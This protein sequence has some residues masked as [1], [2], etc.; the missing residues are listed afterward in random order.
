M[1]KGTVWITRSLP[2]ARQ[3]AD[4][5]QAAGF[6]TYINPLIRIGVP[7]VMPQPLDKRD[8]LLITSTNAL[9]F[10]EI[11]TDRRDWPV[12]TVGDASAHYARKMGFV[13]VL[14]ARG[15]AKDLLALSQKIYSPNT[16]R[17]FVYA[18][19]RHVSFDL[20]ETLRA[21]G[22]KARRDI[23]YH[24]DVRQYANIDSAPPL[25]HLAVYS[26]MAARAARRF[27]GQVNGAKT[28]SI[29]ANADK[30]LGERYKNR[31]LIAGRPNEQAMIKAVSA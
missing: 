5:W 24:N 1:S 15:T 27:A 4:A 19:A 10:L 2:G 14:S 17:T 9:R 6:E 18:S 20:S 26:P 3:S 8:V 16:P 28:I 21:R 12:M 22:F 7:K 25:T 13:D 30:A 23:Y 31:R 11:L 29:S